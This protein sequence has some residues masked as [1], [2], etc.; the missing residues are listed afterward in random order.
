MT[1]SERFDAVLE[2]VVATV[3]G[4]PSAPDRVLLMVYE[5]DLEQDFG[6]A[7]GEFLRTLAVRN[8][9]NAVLDLRW[10]SPRAAGGYGRCRPRPHQPRR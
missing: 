10:C 1:F 8:L 4:P 7:L 2:M 9:P 3:S 5:P 6:V